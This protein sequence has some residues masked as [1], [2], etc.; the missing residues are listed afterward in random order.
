MHNPLL[1]KNIDLYAPEHVGLT[2]LL[3][4]QSPPWKEGST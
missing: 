2:D 3:A 4:A 1:L